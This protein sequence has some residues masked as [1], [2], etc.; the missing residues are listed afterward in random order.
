MRAASAGTS[1]RGGAV[2]A[3]DGGGIRSCSRSRTSRA[4]AATTNTTSTTG[5]GTSTTATRAN[6]ST[7][8]TSSAASA[9]TSGSGGRRSSGGRVGH[10]DTYTN[11]V[12]NSNANS[13][14][15]TNSNSNSSSRSISRG[16]SGSRGHSSGRAAAGG[17][18]APPQHADDAAASNPDGSAEGMATMLGSRHGNSRNRRLHA[19][20]DASVVTAAGGDGADTHGATGTASSVTA[21]ISAAGAADKRDG[22]DDDDALD[23]AADAHY[24]IQ[25]RSSPAAIVAALLAAIATVHGVMAV[26]DGAASYPP[27]LRPVVTVWWYA[28]ITAASTA[29][30]LLPFMFVNSSTLRRGVLGL[31]NAAA[32]GAMAA[33]AAALAFEGATDA[34]ELIVVLPETAPRA[35]ETILPETGT[36]PTV[37]PGEAAAA[38]GGFASLLASIPPV[39]RVAAGCALGALF[40]VGTQ[41]VLAKYEHLKFSGFSGLHARK[42]LLIMA[43]MTLHSAAEGIGIGVSFGSSSDTFGAFISATLAAHNVPEGLAVRRHPIVR[44]FAFLARRQRAQTCFVSF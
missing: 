42:M 16:H 27:A 21:T 12:S 22:D 32:A 19:P 4:A 31:C 38:A 7:T 13:N 2:M 41:A 14:S 26:L 1:T 25:R 28:W 20:N 3:D 6:T 10:R 15:N 11:T 8:T 39:V 9:S 17:T 37:A 36:S 44:Y 18:A 34:H 33:A 40:I 30:G 23:P 5:T 29:A 43:V 24:D 35:S